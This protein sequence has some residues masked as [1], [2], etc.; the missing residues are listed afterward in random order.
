MSNAHDGG[1]RLRC[2]G[3]TFRA[4]PVVAALAA[5]LIAAPPRVGAQ[6]KPG[7]S[8]RQRRQRPPDSNEDTRE[9]RRSWFDGMSGAR[10]FQPLPEDEGPLSQ[11]EQRE[12][13]KFVKK[14]APLIHDKLRQLRKRNP[15]VFQQR[16][17][18]AA[19]RLRMLRRVF[20]RDPRLGRMIVR[21]AENR[22]RFGRARQALRDAGDDPQAR[23]RI[24]AAVRRMMAEDL[25]IEATV[26]DDRAKMMEEQRDA[27]I[28]SEYQRLVSPDLDLA[29]EAPEARELIQRLRGAETDEQREALADELWWVA[30][31]RTDREVETM[32]ARVTR[33]RTHAAEEVDRRVRRFAA[34]ADRQRPNAGGVK[35]R[36]GDGPPKSGK[37]RGDRPRR[38]P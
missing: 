4:L 19:P 2:G 9:A 12:L 31:D 36:Q 1:V 14:H 25:R 15:N 13:E 22:Q 21:Y 30:T 38:R 27:R 5:L 16:M 20:Q 35:A 26:L 37:R 11:A 3:L 23:R 17:Q 18:E 8:H 33:M 6:D 28:E 10:M 32:R 24:A 29:A 34:Q 7:D